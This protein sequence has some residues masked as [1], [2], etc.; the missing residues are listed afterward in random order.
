MNEYRKDRISINSWR[1][2][3]KDLLSL[4]SFF[5]K[6]FEKREIEIHLDSADGNSAVF[7]KVE[8]FLHELEKNIK[9]NKQVDSI[10]FSAGHIWGS[11]IEKRKS[12]WIEIRFDTN[13]ADFYIYGQ[14]KDGSLKEWVNNTY[15][16]LRKVA[17]NISELNKASNQVKLEFHRD[18]K[19]QK[20]NV[21]ATSI[22]D[23]AFIP[24]KGWFKNPAQLFS[25]YLSV[26]GITVS[27]TSLI[28]QILLK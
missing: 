10:L 26:A 8:K 2:G 16:D 9:K 18:G 4:Y 19:V 3:R 20:T 27:V 7:W 23:L 1:V 17:E 22:F 11:N 15:E 5:A 6:R 13:E 14:D 21:L 25:I 24:G 12:L 28:L